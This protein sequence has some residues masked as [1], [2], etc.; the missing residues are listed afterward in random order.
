MALF[1]V[2]SNFFIE[3]HRKTYPFDVVPS[4]WTKIQQLANSG[5]IYSC[6]K[7]HNEICSGK[8]VLAGWIGSALPASFF[9]KSSSVLNEY[10]NVTKWAASSSHYTSTA[11]SEFLA[12]DEADAWLVAHAINDSIIDEII[13][14]THEKSDPM[15]KKRIKI[16]EAC[17]KFGLR[18][19]NT[20]EM[21]RQ[22]GQTF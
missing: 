15:L 9:K 4:F 18:F 12:V 8:D 2:D 11:I 22:L 1:I 5:S 20:I 14:V 19:M 16:P 17:N 3:A 7:V 6:D 10:K 21:F 13:V